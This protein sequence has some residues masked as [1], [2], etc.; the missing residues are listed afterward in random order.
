[1]TL[2]VRF[3]A[4]E[5]PLLVERRQQDAQRREAEQQEDAAKPATEEDGRVA[6]TELPPRATKATVTAETKTPSSRK[7]NGRRVKAS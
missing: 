5:N 3:H 6:E 7:S 1:V 4:P 2:R